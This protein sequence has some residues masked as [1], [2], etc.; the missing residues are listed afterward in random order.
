MLVDLQAGQ[1]HW[2]FLS[3]LRT[4]TSL[5]YSSDTE[6]P[7]GGKR[8]GVTCKDATCFKSDLLFLL[9]CDSGVEKNQ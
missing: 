5:G 7:R 2:P 8:V 6:F 9:G 1:A 4:Q 3:I